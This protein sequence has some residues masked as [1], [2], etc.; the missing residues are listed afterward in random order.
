MFLPRSPRPHFAVENSVFCD[1]P[2]PHPA[3]VYRVFCGNH[4][5]PHFG[6]ENSFSIAITPDSVPQLTTGFL[7]TSFLFHSTVRQSV[8]SSITSRPHRTFGQMFFCQSPSDPIPQLARD[9]YPQ[10][11]LDSIPRLATVFRSTTTF[12]PH[13]KDPKKI[14]HSYLLIFLNTF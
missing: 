3:V 12:R 10:S 8:Y 6:V 4:P 5:R 9:I 13:R 11:P 7:P 14:P 2:R 1:H